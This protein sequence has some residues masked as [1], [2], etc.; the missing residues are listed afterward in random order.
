[1]LAADLVATLEVVGNRS[2]DLALLG[3]AYTV[4]RPTRPIAQR[5]A[6]NRSALIRV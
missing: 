3:G 2:G 5:I 6:G 4:A 1:M